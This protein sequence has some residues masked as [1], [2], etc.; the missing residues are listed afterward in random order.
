MITDEERQ[1]KRMLWEYGSTDDR[2]KDINIQIKL[3]KETKQSM[4]DISSARLD[5]LP[6]GSAVGDP[7]AGAAIKI[8]DRVEM[9][10]KQLISELDDIYE[11]Q[12]RMRNL[13]SCLNREEH[14]LIEWRYIKRIRWNSLPSRMHCSRSTCFNI[15]DRAMRKLIAKNKSLD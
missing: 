9:N 5:G 15:H 2:I 4:R 12:D 3:Q 1:M 6:S 14:R 10:L 11:M 8:V 7:V 13:L